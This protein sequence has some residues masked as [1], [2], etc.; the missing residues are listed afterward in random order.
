MNKNTLGGF[1]SLL[2][3]CGKVESNKR[4]GRKRC[5]DEMFCFIPIL[6]EIAVI[7]KRLFLVIRNNAMGAEVAGDLCHPTLC[8][9]PSIQINKKNI[10]RK[11]VQIKATPHK[12]HI[13]QEKIIPT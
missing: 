12:T 5:M 13:P 1:F 8:L 10:N 6:F 2:V 4:Y 11:T 3:M 7:C 9:Q